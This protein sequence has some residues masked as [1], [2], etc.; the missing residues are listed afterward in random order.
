MERF[1]AENEFDHDALMSKVTTNL[2][3][4]KDRLKSI[5]KSLSDIS[6]RSTELMSDYSDCDDIVEIVSAAISAKAEARMKVRLAKKFVANPMPRY[7]AKFSSIADDAEAH[8]R[9]S[10]HHL[11]KAEGLVPK[12]TMKM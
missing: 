3:G 1:S 9:V 10:K 11:A 4:S 2:N 8:L 12:T 7:Q 6:K 5:E